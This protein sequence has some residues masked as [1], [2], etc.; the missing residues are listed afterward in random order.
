MDITTIDKALDKLSAADRHLFARLYNPAIYDGHLIAPDSMKSWIA[1]QFGSL[2]AVTEQRVVRLTNKVT[3]EETIF[4]PL[5]LKR[6]HDT[7][8]AAG[9]SLDSLDKCL[10]NFARP[11][12]NTP[13]DTFG[14]I[15]GQYCITASNIAKCDGQH[16]LVIFNEHHPLHF[17]EAEVIDYLDTAWRWAE[18]AH[19]ANPANKYFFYS[20]NCLWRSAASLTH[21]HNQMMLTRGRHFAHIEH[22][23]KCA[24]TYRRRHKQDYFG[25][26]SRLHQALGLV[27][28]RQ[29]VCALAYL[30][31]LKNNEVVIL[32]KNM[33][34]SFQKMVYRMLS[35]YRDNLGI[36]SFNLAVTTPPLGPTRESWQDFPVIAWLVD[37]GK[38][39]NPSCDMGALELFASTSVTSD[40][41]LLATKMKGFIGAKWHQVLPCR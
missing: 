11:R 24:L 4:N 13:E 27:T 6:P 10:D 16:G 18:T 38:L 14:R 34:R 1:N 37:R 28:Y 26:I 41:F 2:A 25:D 12:E 9:C 15:Q 8:E 17:N 30:T 35:F 21:G 22:L 33:G 36:A 40:P 20:W 32:A 39:D 23:R 3:G 7:R 31:P 5:R 19:R 29:E